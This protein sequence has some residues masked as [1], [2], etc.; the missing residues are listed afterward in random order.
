MERALL[1]I[2]L[3]D[4]K[5][6]SISRENER[7][8][9]AMQIWRRE[10][11]EAHDRLRDGTATP[12]DRQRYT[13]ALR[14]LRQEMRRW[15]NELDATVAKLEQLA[16]SMD[17]FIDNTALPAL[18]RPFT[19]SG[20]PC[21]CLIEKQAQLAAINARL[22]A[23]LARRAQLQVQLRAAL[24]QLVLAMALLAVA[25]LLLPGTGPTP[26]VLFI[27]IMALV[28][29]LLAAARASAVAAILSLLTDCRRQIVRN[30]LLYYR[31]QLI[32]TCS[33]DK[34]A[35]RRKP[36]RPRERG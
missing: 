1:A 21:E 8:I 29:F 16:E 34:A 31:T 23:E 14:R 25:A 10:M 19:G 36:R 26:L 18:Q 35:R 28:A 17:A 13:R 33:R 30:A 2:D 11:G 12:Q 27:F 6:G 15:E 22:S 20:K 32:P 5:I 9:R 4:R 24:D 3:D 7:R